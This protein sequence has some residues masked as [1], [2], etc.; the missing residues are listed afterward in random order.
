MSQVPREQSDHALQ[1]VY[2]VDPNDEE[3]VE[4]VLTIKHSSS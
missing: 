1:A 4:V 2:A 3:K